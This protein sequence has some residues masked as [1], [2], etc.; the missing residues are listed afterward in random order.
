MELKDQVVSLEL[1]RELKKAG[2]PQK[3]YFWWEN[4]YRKVYYG[5][6]NHEKDDGSY[7]RIFLHK[8]ITSPEYC[9][10]PTVA[11]L[12]ERLPDYFHSIRDKGCFPNK[13]IA[14]MISESEYVLM[15]RK[16]DKTVSKSA[17]TEANARA[18]MWLYLKKEKLL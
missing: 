17:D 6:V 16:F 12:G 15:D 11:E 2:Y 3:G 10:T 9:V 14:E 13:W 4:G 8:P 5:H 1:S 7:W 18:K